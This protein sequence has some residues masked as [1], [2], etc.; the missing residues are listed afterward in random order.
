MSS[1]TYLIDV[2]PSI[3]SGVACLV[4][5]GWPCLR[6][7]MLL[8]VRTT[9]TTTHWIVDCVMI[10]LVLSTKYRCPT[11]TTNWSSDE[12][13][14]NSSILTLLNRSFSTSRIC[15]IYQG[16]LVGEIWSCLWVAYY[17]VLLHTVA[18][19]SLQPLH[20][21]CPNFIGGWFVCCMCKNHYKW[22]T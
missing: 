2:F 7:N 20:Q 17:I 3:E 12:L 1:N 11:G 18:K 14:Q 21:R 8:P 6:L 10:V 4:E 22:Y 19:Y 9:A 13:W 5:Q 15:V 16:C